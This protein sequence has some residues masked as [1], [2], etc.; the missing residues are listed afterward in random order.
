MFFKTM[1]WLT[2]ILIVLP[3]PFKVFEIVTGKDKR[4]LAVKVEE[5]SNAVLLSIGL[6]GFW[7]YAFTDKAS[8]SP[9]LWY[10]W[11][12]LTVLLSILAVF[13]SSK[14]RYANEQVGSK[15][16]VILSVGSTLFFVPLFVAVFNYAAR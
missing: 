2:A 1:F 14:L 4:P 13:K 16:T 15:A 12:L 7:Y 9:W 10:G 6:I 3:F 5:L 11:L 8:N